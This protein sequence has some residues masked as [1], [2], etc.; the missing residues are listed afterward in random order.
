MWS[1]EQ[2]LAVVVVSEIIL[3]PII[4]I[5]IGVNFQNKKG[6]IFDL[7]D[8]L[9][10]YQNQYSSAYKAN[11][12]YVEILKILADI[13]EYPKKY[14]E[15]ENSIPSYY[16]AQHNH[17]LTYK[18]KETSREFIDRL[19]EEYKEKQQAIECAKKVKLGNKYLSNQG[20]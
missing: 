8:T 14:K 16:Q 7:T 4:G 10:Y 3:I 17:S 2:I 15:I 19:L 5:I 20:V 12:Q 13:L 1:S 6:I 11:E 18:R 9:K